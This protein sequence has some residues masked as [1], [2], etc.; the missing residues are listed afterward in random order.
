MQRVVPKRVDF[1]R[2]ADARRNGPI[3]DFCIHP[4][5]L[6]A[7]FAGVDKTVRFI[8]MNA[9]SRAID[10]GSDDL[11]QNRVQLRHGFLVL[12]RFEVL[13]DGFEVP[14]GCINGVVFRLAATV[15]E[16][17][18]QHSFVD[19]MGKRKKNF[20][21]DFWTAS[22][23][24]EARKRDHRVAPPIAEPVIARED[25]FSLRLFRQDALHDE[26]IGG[27]NELADPCGGARCCGAIAFRPF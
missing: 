17:V 4:S 25:G 9:V 11:S 24:S 19:V 15:R 2:L 14:Q 8:H 1:H 22:G 20:P 10:V 3:P 12:G 5:E 18:G 27:K 13:P 26:L 6:H 16:M 7:L 21:G 23:Q